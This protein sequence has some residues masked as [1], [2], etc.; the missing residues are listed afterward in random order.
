M[1]AIKGISNAKK[2]PFC[3][4]ARFSVNLPQFRPF[5]NALYISD[6]L[7]SKQLTLT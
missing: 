1:I 3:Q 4:P 2:R 7:Y 5:Q 6:S